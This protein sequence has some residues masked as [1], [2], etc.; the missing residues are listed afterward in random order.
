VTVRFTLIFGLCCC[1]DCLTILPTPTLYELSVDKFSYLLNQRK[2]GS[3]SKDDKTPQRA[4]DDLQK[5]VD[6]CMKPG[7]RRKCLLAHFGESNRDPRSVCRG[8]CDFCKDPRAVEK[9]I[10]EASASNDFSFQTRRKPEPKAKWDGQWGRPLGDDDSH[11][12]DGDGDWDVDGLDITGNRQ[13]GGYD[14]DGASRGKPSANAVLS[15]FE[16]SVSTCSWPHC[17]RQ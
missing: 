16:V 3:K 8:N 15:K 13:F 1:S 6:Y 9:E 10:E 4:L 12:P 2:K 11:F 5:M 17:G 7:C 14:D